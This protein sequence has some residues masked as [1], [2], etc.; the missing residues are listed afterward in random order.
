MKSSAHQAIQ[1]GQQI[2]A[3]A[4]LKRFRAALPLVECNRGF[5]KYRIRKEAANESAYVEVMYEIRMSYVAYQS[6]PMLAM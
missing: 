1:K 4:S 2:E 3:L 6:R 5:F